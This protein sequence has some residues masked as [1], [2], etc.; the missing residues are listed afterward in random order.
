MAKLKD[1]GVAC[2]FETF[3]A[4]DDASAQARADTNLRDYSNLARKTARANES[5]AWVCV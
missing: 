4:W 3:L 5:A 2:A 1:S